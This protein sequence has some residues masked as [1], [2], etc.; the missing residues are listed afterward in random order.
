MT[1]ADEQQ[2]KMVNL[3]DRKRMNYEKIL[4]KIKDTKDFQTLKELSKNKCK[5]S[6]NTGDD[7]EVKLNEDGLYENDVDVNM[8]TSF[9]RNGQSIIENI[10]YIF[11]HTYIDTTSSVKQ[12]FGHNHNRDSDIDLYVR[13]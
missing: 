6:L 8:S 4:V 2:T 3:I 1:N 12:F 5:V 7:K 13:Y 11:V 10:L 9:I